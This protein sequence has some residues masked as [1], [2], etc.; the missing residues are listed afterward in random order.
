MV[1]YLQGRRLRI[2]SIALLGLVCVNWA[3]S[4]ASP[5]TVLAIHGSAHRQV[6]G[7]TIRQRVWALRQANG[8]I[9][10]GVAT[11]ERRDAFHAPPR[12]RVVCLGEN[13]AMPQGL[14][15]PLGKPGLLG[16]ALLSD[17]GDEQMSETTARS[18]SRSGACVPHWFLAAVASVIPLAALRRAMKPADPPA[19]P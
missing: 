16:F 15:I 3:L 1:L 18:T 12:N 7:R 14:P 19:G 10:M 8:C 11:R 6:D 2:I 4:H 5:A 13:D 17:S 9:A